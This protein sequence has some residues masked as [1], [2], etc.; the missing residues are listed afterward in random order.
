[1]Q[2]IKL[3]SGGHLLERICFTLKLRPEH[4]EEYTRRHAEVWPEMQDALRQAGWANYSLFLTPE[5]LLI[6]YL[7]TASFDEAKQKM[8][9]LEVNSRWQAEMAPFFDLHGGYPDD[10]MRPI[11]EIFH[12]D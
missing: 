2:I 10:D 8:K 9:S 1:M 11:A 4:I 12:L 5:G 7:E 6:G 3:D